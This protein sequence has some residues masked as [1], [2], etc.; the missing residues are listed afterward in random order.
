[1]PVITQSTSIK[2]TPKELFQFFTKSANIVEVSPTMPSLVFSSPK[3]LLGK[4]QQIHFELS[5]GVFKLSWVSKITKFEPYSFFEDTLVK[6]P[7]KK[8][9]QRH[10][11]EEQGNKTLIQ[12]EIEYEVGYGPLGK[13]MDTLIVRYQIENFF[14]KRLKKTTEKFQH[15]HRNLA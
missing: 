7:F 2:C 11:F 5:Y 12:D 4:S 14:R 10:H 13:I 9:I 8:W 3:L 15:I 6:G 1:M